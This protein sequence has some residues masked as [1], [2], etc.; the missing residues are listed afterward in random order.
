MVGTHEDLLLPD[1]DLAL[2]PCFKLLM[3]VHGE[4]D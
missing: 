3:N 4:L 2:I 1:E